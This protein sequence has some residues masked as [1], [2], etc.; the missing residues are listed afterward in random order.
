MLQNQLTAAGINVV[1]EMVSLEGAK[2]R[3]R[4]ALEILMGG[5][6][7]ALESFEKWSSFV[8]NH[9]EQRAAAAAAAMAWERS[10]A[11]PN[12]AAVQEMRRVVPL[13]VAS[14]SKKE[15]IGRGVHPKLA[16]RLFE[17]K[18]LW[19]VRMDPKLIAKLHVADLNVKVECSFLLCKSTAL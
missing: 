1:T 13:D 7:S 17:K 3:L 5:D 6:E 19:F 2:Q 8:E 18:V 10:N 4:E 11:Q 16:R 9:P 14:V 15:L 12:A